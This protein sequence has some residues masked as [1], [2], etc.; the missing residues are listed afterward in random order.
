MSG[1]S[2]RRA[3]RR[4]TQQLLKSAVASLT[5][6]QR[7]QDPRVLRNS[8]DEDDPR[9]KPWTKIGTVGEG[10]AH[11]EALLHITNDMRVQQWRE[12][13][14]QAARE[15]RDRR[16]EIAA[17]LAT[18][19]SGAG[20]PPGRP[21]ALKVELAKV[22]QL[23]AAVRMAIRRIDVTILRALIERIDFATGRLF[24]SIDRIASDAGC[25][26]NS[27]IAALKRLKFHGFIDW[28][29]RSVRTGNDG[30]FAPQ[31]EQTSNAYYFRHR[32][33]MAART[34]QRFIQVLTAKLRRLGKAPAALREP[35]PK[36][37]P[38]DDPSG[39]HEALSALGASVANAST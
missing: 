21:A 13:T 2:E 15:A 16:D 8:Y 19:A 1:A 22:E 6:K 31:R 12:T 11:R 14:P 26:R 32:Q 23:L 18:I 24:P 33:T 29:R 39:L 20:S 34:W 30:Q 7:G 37:P 25:H 38:T 10:L 35:P 4:E 3:E 28:V 5:G 17:E 9:A 27:V 36:I